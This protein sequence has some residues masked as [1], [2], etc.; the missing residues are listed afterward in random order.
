MG[1][2]QQLRKKRKP[3]SALP[4][5]S[6]RGPSAAEMFFACPGS[7]RMN[8]G[9]PNEDTIYSAEGTFLHLIAAECLQFGL[10]P[11]DYI[12]TAA[13]IGTF[14]FEFTAAHAKMMQPGLDRIRELGGTVYVELRV[15]LERWS[16]GDFGTLDVGVITPK[17]IYIIDWKFGEGEPVDPVENK[18]MMAYGVAFWYEIARHLTDA[19]D[20][21]LIIEQPR[22]PGGGGEWHTTV[23]ELWEFG[24]EYRRRCAATREPDA[25]LVAGEKQCRWCRAFNDCPAAAK[26]MAKLM[27]TKFKDLDAARELDIE[28]PVVKPKF[29]TPERR[30][31]IV[32]HAPMLSRWLEVLRADT[33]SDA[34]AGRPTPELKAVNGRKGHRHWTD[35]DRVEKFLVRRLDDKAFT[36]ELKSPAQVEEILPAEDFKKLKKFIDQS[37]GKPTLVSLDDA[38]EAIT[39]NVVKFENL[40]NGEY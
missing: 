24:K 5:H 14:R 20:V 31:Y 35:K 25:P 1:L 21:T 3:A 7:I 32:R 18:Q 16:E 4:A 11:E 34:L 30:S 39:P 27:G 28:P 38:R 33:L 19:E 8:E 6:P 22:A 17:R 40:N 37:E 26:F 9:R 10:E 29:L 2:T 12:G 15:S 23:D 13:K 36:K